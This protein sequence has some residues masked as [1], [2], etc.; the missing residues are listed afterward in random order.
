MVYGLEP[1]RVAVIAAFPVGMLVWLWCAFRGGAVSDRQ[2]D[3]W[4]AQARAERDAQA[5]AVLPAAEWHPDWPEGE[6]S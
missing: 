6:A 4:F 2:S 5:D 1:A 3:E